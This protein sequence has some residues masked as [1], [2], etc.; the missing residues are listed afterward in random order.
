[1]SNLSPAQPTPMIFPQIEDEKLVLHRD[2]VK[3][4][5][6]LFAL[7]QI[8]LRLDTEYKVKKKRYEKIDKQ[9]ALVDGRLHIVKPNEKAEKNPFSH[10]SQDEINNLVE[11]LKELIK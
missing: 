1:M 6:E 11:E 2:I 5:N 10:M 9:R 8:Y 3:L 7:K 4:K